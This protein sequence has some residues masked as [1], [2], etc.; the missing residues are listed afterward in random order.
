MAFWEV[1]LGG[2]IGS[3]VATTI[4]GTLLARRNA[5]QVAEVKQLF[6]ERMHAFTIARA[7][8]QAALYELFGPMKMQFART[9]RAMKRW[10]KRNDHLEANVILTSNRAV[11]DLL[12]A[13]GHLIPPDLPEPA[14]QLIEHYDAWI[15]KFE[16]E[17]LAGGS[18]AE[19]TFVGPDGFP[20]PRKAEAAML[21]KADELQAVLYGIAA[22]PG[23]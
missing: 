21:A 11:R 22:G 4:I 15:E 3:G 10:N 6:D 7:Y 1:T 18:T 20:F 13:K 14:E 8:R 19:F 2:L 12:L 23:D 16:S 9:R 17:R 5:R